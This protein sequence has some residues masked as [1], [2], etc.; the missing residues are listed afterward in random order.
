MSA[1]EY[2]AHAYAVV[3]RRGSD[4]LAVLLHGLG[5]DSNQPLGLTDDQLAGTHIDVLAPDA[6]AHGRTMLIGSA[7]RFSTEAMAD[8]VLALIDQL[9]FGDHRL[10]PIGISMGAAVALRLAE[11]VPDRVAGALL[12]RPAFGPEPWPVHAASFAVIADLL[13]RFGPDGASRYRQS[14]EH[15]AVAE[16]SASGATSLVEQFTKPYAVERVVRLETVPGNTAVGWEGARDLGMPVT[17]IGAPQDPVHP[18][19]MAELWQQRIAGAT[20]E[21][22]PARD[23]DPDGYA[24]AL[25]SI[26][27]ERV[28]AW[29]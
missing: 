4:H 10:I 27:R 20:L 6:R 21:V 9:G 17:V 11:T 18:V 7:D 26:V 13:R 3:H 28:V 22:V 1:Q 15:R 29:S 8:D 14:G 24:A 25:E 19:A 16:V 23:A 5:G 12:I 2:A